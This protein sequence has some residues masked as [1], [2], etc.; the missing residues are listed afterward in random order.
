MAHRAPPTPQ[1]PIGVIA[2]PAGEPRAVIDL[3][4]DDPPRT[5][6][7]DTTTGVRGAR[8]ED[9][10]LLPGTPAGVRGARAASARRPEAAGARRLRAAG[11]RRLRIPATTVRHAGSEPC[12]N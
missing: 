5:V 2:A 7:A 4:S 12:H 3:F 6:A 11:A 9:H 10:R 1:G 8:G